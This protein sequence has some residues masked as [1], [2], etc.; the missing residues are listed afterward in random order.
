MCLVMAQLRYKFFGTYGMYSPAFTESPSGFLK[1][2]G[3]MPSY[4]KLPTEQPHYNMSCTVRTGE[5]GS[6]KKDKIE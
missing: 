4:E 3:P 2:T 1:K 6:G 5:Y